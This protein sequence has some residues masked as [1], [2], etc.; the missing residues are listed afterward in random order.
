MAFWTSSPAAEDARY[1]R[2][3]TLP[4]SRRAAFAQPARPFPFLAQTF[5]ARASLRALLAEAFPHPVAE[6]LAL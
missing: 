1:P 6:I 2:F 5:K 3:A 4:N